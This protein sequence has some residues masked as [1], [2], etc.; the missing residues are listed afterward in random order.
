[1]TTDPDLPPLYARWMTELLPSPIPREAEAPCLQCVLRPREKPETA[2]DVVFDSGVKCCT[3]VPEL[4]NFLVGRILSDEDPAMATGRSTVE[5]RIQSGAAVTPLG[6]GLQP[7]ERQKYAQILRLGTFGKDRT[8]YCPHYVKEGGLCGV[9]RHRNSVCATWFCRHVRGAVGAR[10]WRSVYRLLLSCERALTQWCLLKLIDDPETLAHA[11]RVN[12]AASA[13]TD[14]SEDAETRKKMWGAWW[15]RKKEFFRECAKLVDPL[16]WSEV[17]AL[18]GPEGRIWASVVRQTHQAMLDRS[19]P[20]NLHAGAF[21]GMPLDGARARVWGNNMFQP[22][23]VPAAWVDTLSRLS[24]ERT[25]RV[26][27]KLGAGEDQIL[28][29]LDLGILDASPRSA[30]EKA[31]QGKGGG[32]FQ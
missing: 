13:D 3:Y 25:D 27:D 11:M 31:A 24:G 19:L 22:V 8:H 4:H 28:R 26:L 10:F 29:F 2:M 23:D 5:F 30:A 14:G 7:A 16:P 12:R 20:A 9:W 15:T 6:L 18:A 17:L 21:G 1:M 32:F